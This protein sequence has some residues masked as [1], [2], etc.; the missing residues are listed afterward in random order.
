MIFL[1]IFLLLSVHLFLSFYDAL[2][3]SRVCLC[4]C[5]CVCVCVKF[6]PSNSVMQSESQ[7]LIVFGFLQQTQVNI[8]DPKHNFL[9]FFFSQSVSKKWCFFSR[10]PCRLDLDQGM[11]GSTSSL[12][13]FEN[14]CSSDY[15]ISL[16]LAKTWGIRILFSPSRSTRNVGAGLSHPYNDTAPLPEASHS[17]L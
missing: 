5:V 7:T 10:R 9:I 15:L 6:V 16:T 3:K 8:W 17:A 2:F 14:H 1:C 11:R 4:V 13:T 12:S